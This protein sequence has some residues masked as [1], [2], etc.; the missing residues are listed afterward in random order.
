MTSTSASLGPEQPDERSIGGI[1]VHLV[2]LFT[3]FFGPIILYAVSDNEFTRTNARHAINWHVT[4]FIL[5]IVALVM[6]FLGANE[7][8]VLGEATTVS[9]LP[10]PL[11]V[12]FGLVGF[13]L[14]I[15]LVIALFLTFVY[16]IVA[17]VKAIAGS[18]WTYPGA[19]AFVERYR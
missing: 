13:L 9:L 7:I 17:T 11:D 1:L 18:T 3:G 6:F 5:M 14:M 8:T 16:T 15:V 4:V 10:A 19:I 12:V 2:G